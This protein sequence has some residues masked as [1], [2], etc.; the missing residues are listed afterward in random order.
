P[1]AKEL[2]LINITLGG[3][4]ADTQILKSLRYQFPSA[5]IRHI[6]ASTEAGVGFSVNDGKAGFPV[7]Y[8]NSDESGVDLKIDDSGQLCIKP[9]KIS[10]H[11]ISGNSMH[12]QD[13]YI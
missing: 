3:E 8:L 10:Q 12:S 9:N 11:Y 6:Y 1:S 4:I 13:G 2:K 5:K 7:S